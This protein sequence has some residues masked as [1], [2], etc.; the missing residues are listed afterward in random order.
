VR[1]FERR[2]FERRG[3]HAARA[4]QQVVRL[5]DQHGHA[6][7]GVAHGGVQEG[8]AVEVVVVVAHDGVGPV[9]HFLREE[10]GAHLV[11]EGNVA[12]RLPVEPGDLR[13]LLA[14]G[15]QAVVEAAGQRA[16]VAVA[17]AVGVLAH[18]LARREFQHAQP[19]GALPLV[20]HAQRIE[21]HRAA[22]GLGGEEEELVDLL[23]RPRLEQRKD[24]GQRLADAGGR[25]RHE[26]APAH[27]GAVHGLG[28]FAL[29]GAEAAVR[30]L[31][32]RQGVVERARWPASLAAQAL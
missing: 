14:R 23:R 5:V 15:G 30:K 31:Q 7:V 18:L 4:L 29:A 25:L 21:R 27:A 16:G 22:R 19:A 13:G 3:V 11:R 24:G 6:P 12:Q 8:A 28:Q 10:I 2:A 1:L 17:G 20:E 9:R 32:L 26:A